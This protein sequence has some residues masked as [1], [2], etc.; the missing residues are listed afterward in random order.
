[1]KKLTNFFKSLAQSNSNDSSK[2]FLA[3]YVTL[4]LITFIVL[5]YTND[6]NNVMVLTT[7]CGFVLALVG[8]AS[9]QSIKS[10]KNDNGLK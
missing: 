7:L 5:L 3:I 8:V 1:M 6:K 9:W 2:R 4:A 10:S